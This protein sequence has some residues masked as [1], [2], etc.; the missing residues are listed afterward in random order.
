MEHRIGVIGLVLLAMLAIVSGVT[1]I[2]VATGDR[3]YDF[4]SRPREEGR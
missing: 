1:S 2:T 3:V 4:S